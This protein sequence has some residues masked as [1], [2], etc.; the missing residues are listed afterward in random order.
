MEV[1]EYFR[2]DKAEELE[3]IEHIAKSVGKWR[4]VATKYGIS[5]TNQ[6]IKAPAFQVVE[7]SVF[8]G[9]KAVIHPYSIRKAPC[10][11]PQD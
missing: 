8:Q 7:R 4:K 3:I 1:H 9:R 5:K 11:Y 6:E 10:S 2:L